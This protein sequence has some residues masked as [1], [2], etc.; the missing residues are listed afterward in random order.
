MSEI[1][2]DAARA[3][4]A[5]ARGEPHHLKLG[6]DKF[7]LPGELPWDY[8]DILDTGDMKAALKMLLNGTFERFWGHDP[9]TDDMQLLATSV[10]ALYGF[11]KGHPESS[12]SGGSS[13]P[14]G[15]PSRPTSPAG[16][17]STSAKRSTAR[18][19]PG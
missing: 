18:R 13:A 1:D 4:R 17:T 9:T 14:T 11:G 15:K 10:P 12:A 8:F 7:E 6:G 2:L 5:E 3:A 16:T 19:R